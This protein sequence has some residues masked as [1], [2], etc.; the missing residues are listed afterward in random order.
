MTGVPGVGVAGN[1]RCRI[2]YYLAL[3]YQPGTEWRGPQNANAQ[4][5]TPRD[6]SVK[7]ALRSARWV[8]GYASIAPLLQK[9]SETPP[10]AFPGGT[11]A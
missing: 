1:I 3:G 6:E 9:R 8:R 10:V 5:A 7:E 2:R 11:G 4:R